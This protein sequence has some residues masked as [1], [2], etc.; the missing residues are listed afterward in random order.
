MTKEEEAKVVGYAVYWVSDD[1]QQN[2]LLAEEDN[3]DHAE[4]KAE[5][6]IEGRGL[7][8]GFLDTFQLV[9]DDEAS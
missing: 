8:G 6:E 7:V 4:R 5:E 2:I 1:N 9:A 3:L